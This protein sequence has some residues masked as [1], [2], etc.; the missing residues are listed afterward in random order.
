[1]SCQGEGSE[2]GFSSVLGY[3]S[4]ECQDWVER[5]V[6]GLAEK[7]E[8]VSKHLVPIVNAEID[9]FNRCKV[10]WKEETQESDQDIPDDSKLV[11]NEKGNVQKLNNT[12]D[13]GYG[14]A[15]QNDVSSYVTESN[16]QQKEVTTNK[17]SE[18]PDDS[19]LVKIEAD[20]VEELSNITEVG[21]EIVDQSEG[22]A[23]EN[24]KIHEEDDLSSS[25]A[26]INEQQKETTT[27]AKD[28]S[29][30]DTSGADEL[31]EEDITEEDNLEGTN[32]YSES[33]GDDLTDDKPV[34][35]SEFDKNEE[36]IDYSYSDD[37]NTTPDK[38]SHVKE[39]EDDF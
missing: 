7:K 8:T 38:V 22:L 35:I 10:T 36:N 29:Y 14:V 15:N 12:T 17:E 39:E 5:T 3:S 19:E 13:G 4:Q 31:V 32:Q 23:Q 34:N 33:E 20:N 2:E 1:M 25:E 27:I 24:E 9:K 37:K 26:K 6:K 18:T 30:T 28:E 11:Q 16:E 21:Y